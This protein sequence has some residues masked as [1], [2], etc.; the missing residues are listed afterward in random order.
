MAT[1]N[2]EDLESAIEVWV[3]PRSMLEVGHLLA[4]DEVV[5]VKGRL[6]TKDETPKLIC[7][8]VRKPDLDPSGIQPLHLALP[9]N[10]LS[11]ER[12]ASL[13]KLLV[14]HPS[15]VPVLLHVGAKC[16][17]LASEFSVD[18]TKGLLSELRVLLG[19]ACLGG[20]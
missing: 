18:T 7:L 10:A 15:P 13:K 9:V 4:D 14:D 20:G 6:D 8:E 3:F 17:R 19:P 1:F 12:V 11:D 16:I 2:L 5:C